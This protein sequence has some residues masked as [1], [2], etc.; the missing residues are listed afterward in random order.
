M[1]LTLIARSVRAR[2]IMGKARAKEVEKQ[3]RWP[4]SGQVASPAAGSTSS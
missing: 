3:W 2:N 4:D 1:H